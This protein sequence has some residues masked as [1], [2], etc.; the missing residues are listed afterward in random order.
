MGGDLKKYTVCTL[1]KMLT[2]L[3]GPLLKYNI[4]RVTYYYRVLLIACSS[5]KYFRNSKCDK[6]PLVL[7]ISQPK[8]ISIFVYTEL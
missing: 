7:T 5:S 3:D 6:H 8:L 1:L 2:F 4:R